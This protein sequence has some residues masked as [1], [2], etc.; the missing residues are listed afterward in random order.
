MADILSLHRRG[1]GRPLP[2]QR[3]RRK[4]QGFFDDLPCAKTGFCS[5]CTLPMRICSAMVVLE[6]AGLGAIMGGES[7]NVVIVGEEPGI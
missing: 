3:F 4:V 7:K 6:T 2:S 5:D 1:L